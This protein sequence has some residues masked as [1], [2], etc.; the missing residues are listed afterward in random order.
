V[1]SLRQASVVLTGAGDDSC[2]CTEHTLELVGDDLGGGN[3][4]T[5]VFYSSRKH[6]RAQPQN[7]RRGS[8]VR[9]T[10]CVGCRNGGR[11]VRVTDHV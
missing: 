3:Q 5:G 7:L 8:V 10:I 9:S 2:S 1:Q 11:V 4:K 6:E